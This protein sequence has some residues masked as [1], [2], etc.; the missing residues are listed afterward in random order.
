MA[1]VLAACAAVV[2]PGASAAITWKTPPA[3]VIDNTS[4]GMSSVQSLPRVAMSPAGDSLAMG[5]KGGTSPTILSEV[6]A[7]PA[8]GSFS[9]AKVLAPGSSFPSCTGGSCSVPIAVG[10]DTAG[11]GFAFTFDHDFASAPANRVEEWVLPAGSSTWLGPTTISGTD[12]PDSGDSAMAAVSGSGLE[13]A[14]W[15]T[16]SN[17]N[18]QLRFAT[19]SPGGS[20]STPADVTG[21]SGNLVGDTVAIDSSGDIVVGFTKGPKTQAWAAFKASSSTWTSTQLSLSANT[22]DIEDVKVG[23]DDGGNAIAVW[24]RQV[25]PAGTWSAQQ[26]TRPFASAT[27][28]AAADLAS[29]LTSFPGTRVAVNAAGATVV[30]WNANGVPVATTRSGSGVAFDSPPNTFLASTSAGNPAVAIDPQGT[31]VVVWLNSGTL[32]GGRHPL[33]GGWSTLPDGPSSLGGTPSV[34]V[35]AGGD[36]IAGFTDSMIEKVEAVGL[37]VAGPVLTSAMLPATGIAG[38]PAAFSVAP[39]DVWSSV[40]G[41]TWNFADGT[42]LFGGTSGTHTFASPGLF[43]PTVS[44]TDSVGNTSSRQLSIAVGGTGGGGGG[45]GVL[46]ATKPTISGLGE[47]NSIFVVGPGSTPLTGRTAVRRRRPKGTVFSFRLDQAA[48]V[49]IA[50]QTSARGR[51]VGRSCR[52]ESRRLRS[53]P[54]CTRTITIATLTRTARAGLNRVAFSGRI[55]GRALRPGH[56]QAAFTAIDRAG[57]SPT[58]TLRFTVVSR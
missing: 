35:D 25:S 30:S 26:A 3:T 14:V 21:A 1:L 5:A 48:T 27:W 54:R 43:A 19:R 46:V 56:Y 39:V 23:I 9:A 38:A 44:S 7:R 13:V 40:T 42:G 2:A 24:S 15:R 51:R 16:G 57:A 32:Q 55:R 10:F 4:G 29:G 17:P 31:A 52:A 45:G 41:T 11:N 34:A 58:R 8:G 12:V 49:K 33:G 37:D 47:T 36:A 28:S 22:S 18:F 6:I 50:I 53:R 20:W